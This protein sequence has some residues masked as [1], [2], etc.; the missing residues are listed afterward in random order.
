MISPLPERPATMGEVTVR[1]SPCVCLE[2]QRSS[3]SETLLRTEET[4]VRLFGVLLDFGV[5]GDEARLLMTAL[6]D[7]HFVVFEKAKNL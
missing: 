7:A 3:P 6:E 1:K 2:C 4:D 5:S